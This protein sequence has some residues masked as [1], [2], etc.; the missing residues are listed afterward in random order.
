MVHSDGSPVNCVWVFNGEG[1]QFPGGVFTTKAAAAHWIRERR[2]TGVLT[3]YPVDESAYDRAV[4]TGAF[5]P[6][7]EYHRSPSFI[8]RFTSEAQEH[9]QF[10]DG[11]EALHEH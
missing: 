10:F 9:V 11:N 8:Q 3:A 6:K 1:A 4:R 5:V 7:S 2:L